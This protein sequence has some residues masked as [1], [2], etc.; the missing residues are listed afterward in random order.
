MNAKKTHTAKPFGLLLTGLMMIFLFSACN[1]AQKKTQ[2]EENAETA[3]TAQTEQTAKAE[4]TD[5]AKKS[6]E[7]KEGTLVVT[8]EVL[9]MSCFLDHGAKG[10]GH[11]ACAQACLDKG[12][13]AGILSESGEV[14]LLLE[15]HSKADAY[16]KAVEHAADDVKITGKV[17]TQGGVQGIV[18]EKVE[19]LKG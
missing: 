18:V 4:K 12:L 9:D 8:G 6:E 7:N 1:N 14:Y 17:V 19:V 2:T 5:E 16:A 3:K 11:A 15:N 10:E 13:P